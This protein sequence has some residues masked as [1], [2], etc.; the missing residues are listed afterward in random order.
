MLE[1]KD[2]D[3]F[4]DNLC[5]FAPYQT[6]FP[7]SGQKDDECAD[8]NLGGDDFDS[9]VPLFCLLT[10]RHWTLYYQVL[11]LDTKNVL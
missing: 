9:R 6:E 7:A 11:I 4:I 1:T 2:T 8:L 5:S 10:C 3:L